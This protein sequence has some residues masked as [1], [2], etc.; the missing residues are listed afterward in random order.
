MV[1]VVIAFIVGSVILMDEE[2]MRISLPLIVGTGV[3]SGG[4]IFWL[5]TRLYTMR[6][7]Q[8]VTGM[9]RMIGSTGEAMEDFDGRGR[10]W[11]HGESWA[12]ISPTPVRKGHKVRVT[13]QDGLTLHVTNVEEETP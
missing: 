3:A 12:A 8:V 1:G 4:F 10:I 13:S 5:M 2:S 9:E 6:R 7:K 11:I